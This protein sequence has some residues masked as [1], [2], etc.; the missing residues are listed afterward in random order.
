[1]FPLYNVNNTYEFP[2]SGDVTQGISP[3][4]SYRYE[5]IPEIEYEVTTTVASPGKQLGKLTE[6]VLVIAKKLD[7]DGEDLEKIKELTELSEKIET[8]K[9]DALDKLRARRDQI[10]KRITKLEKEAYDKA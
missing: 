5:G 2:L 8:A 9:K 10:E 7:F 3:V 1:M 6:A 4:F